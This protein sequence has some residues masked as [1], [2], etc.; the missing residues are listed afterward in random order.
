MRVLML[1]K[2][3]VVGLYQRKLE[4][5]ARCGVDLT[6]IV[7]PVWADPSGPQPLER[8]H[9]EGYQ[10]IEAPIR[11]N[12]NFHLFYFPTLPRLIRTYRPDLIH[13]DEEPYNLAAWHALYHA[14]RAKTVL[15]TWQN[16]ARRYPPPFGWGE[17]WALRRTHALIAGT[18]GAADVWRAKGYTGRLPVIPQFG[19]DPDQFRPGPP[20]ADPVIGYVGRLVPEKGVDL[21][22]RAAA[23]LQREGRPVR[24]RIVGSGPEREAL[25]ALA[26]E[27]AAPVDFVGKVPSMQMPTVYPPLSVLAIPSRTR[28]N[29]KEQFG[30]VITEAM[31]AGV[32]VIGSDSGAIPDVIGD[33]GLTFP[34]DDLDALIGA[35]RRVLDSPELAAELARRGRERVIAHYTHRA[36]AEQTAALYRDLL[37]G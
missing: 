33:A 2:A 20:P 28:P 30:R 1:S 22:I 9:T 11:F 13:I 34:E 31:A 29:W 32:P 24:L 8:A 10:L 36:V 17:A 37:S 21:L 14:G 19:V 15:F 18:G 12:G 25:A 6:V 3:C 4:E 35:L 5:I 27:L 26:A 16:I 7:P 23:A